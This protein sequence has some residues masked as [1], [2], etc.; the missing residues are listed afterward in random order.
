MMKRILLTVF[1]LFMGN[2]IAAMDE[3]D[4]LLISF[5]SLDLLANTSPHLIVRPVL[6]QAAQLYRQQHYGDAARSMEPIAEYFQR[7]QSNDFA[8]IAYGLQNELVKKALNK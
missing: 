2:N 7:E 5:K 4:V 1:L 3:V 6:Q 8:S